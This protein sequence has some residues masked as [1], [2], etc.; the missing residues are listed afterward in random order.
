MSRPKPRELRAAQV[1]SAV[2][3]VR[4][5]PLRWQWGR[6]TCVRAAA[7]PS[8]GSDRSLSSERVF[9]SV[10][11]RQRVDSGS[12]GGRERARAEGQGVSGK[13]SSGG[14][15]IHPAPQPAGA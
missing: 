11:V 10:Q 9:A 12:G 14:R 8:I 15:D 7:R 1:S 2:T 3:V 6:G 13:L 4:S 5:R